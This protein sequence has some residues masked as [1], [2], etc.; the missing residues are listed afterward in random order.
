MTYT[1]QLGPFSALEIEGPNVIIM[2]LSVCTTKSSPTVSLLKLE[3]S[4]KVEQTLSIGL[5]A[6]RKYGLCAERAVPE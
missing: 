2:V 1:L 3:Y 5:D 6:E 4:N